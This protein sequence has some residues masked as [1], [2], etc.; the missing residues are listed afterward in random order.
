MGL[1]IQMLN[2]CQERNIN[3]KLKVQL[4]DR[5][6]LHAGG[7][8]VQCQASQKLTDETVSNREFWWLWQTGKYTCL[9][10][11]TAL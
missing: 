1:Q 5:F 11:K 2:R 7:S 6:A 9:N 4:R 8:S 10:E 3:E